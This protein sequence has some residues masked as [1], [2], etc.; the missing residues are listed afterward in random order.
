MSSTALNDLKYRDFLINNKNTDLKPAG[1]LNIIAGFPAAIL[2]HSEYNGIPCLMINAIVDSHFVSTETIKAFQV[3]VKDI[4][5]FK[6]FSFDDLQT[7]PGYKSAVSDANVR[8]NTI[9]T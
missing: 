8:E 2:I 1:V 5:D 7:K 4:L 6:N 9:F 3:V